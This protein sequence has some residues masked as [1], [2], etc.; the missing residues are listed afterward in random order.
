MNQLAG[1]FDD[2]KLVIA[3][4]GDELKKFG[5]EERRESYTDLNRYRDENDDG[6]TG[7]IVAKP[8]LFGRL[9]AKNAAPASPSAD[10]STPGGKR[11]RNHGLLSKAQRTLDIAGWSKAAQGDV[12][13][14]RLVDTEGLTP[15]LS[16]LN[17]ATLERAKPPAPEDNKPGLAQLRDM[18]QS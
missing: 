12:E 7:R 18:R 2:L 3:L 11:M 9:K 8:G 6:V 15:L 13:I 4:K 14:F 17:E 16:V 10:A 5:E 1:V